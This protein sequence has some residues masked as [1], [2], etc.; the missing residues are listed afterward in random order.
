MD[1]R[2]LT[3]S[4]VLLAVAG[5]VVQAE[6]KCDAEPRCVGACT[7]AGLMCLNQLLPGP[8]STASLSD[9]ELERRAGVCEKI[10]QYCEKEC[11]PQLAR[12]YQRVVPD[13]LR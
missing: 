3:L 6:S 2:I 11:S 12:E 8:R 1:M 4:V 13:P 9:A 10:Q 7:A 5:G